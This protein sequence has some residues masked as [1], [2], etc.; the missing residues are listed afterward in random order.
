MTMQH[1]IDAA[2]DAAFER[3]ADLLAE[4]ARP[5]S[6]RD[7]FGDPCVAEWRGVWLTCERERAAVQS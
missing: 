2:A 6:N 1:V 3:Y 7:L 5:G 4:K